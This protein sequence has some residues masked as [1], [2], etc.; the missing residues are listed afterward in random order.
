MKTAVILPAFNEEHNLAPL[1]ARLGH[2]AQ[3]AGLEL[4]IVAVNDGSADDTGRVLAELSRAHGWVHVVE[5]VKNSGLGASIR[6]GIT[7]ALDL[8][9]EAVVMMDADRSHDPDSL[10]EFLKAIQ[11]G[12]DLVLGSRFVSGG[13]MVGVPLWRRLISR[14]GNAIG[15]RVLAIK[16][17]DLT[18]G[19]RAFR[20]AALR[21]LKLTESGFGIQLEGVIEASAAGCAIAEVPIVLACR[22]TG[23]SSMQYG[24]ALFWAYLRVLLHGRRRI[25]AGRRA[26]R[27]EFAG[28]GA[29]S[30]S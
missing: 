7:S 19:Y 25:R 17:R 30:A 22:A 21:N 6:T 10:P 18:T 5:H 1:V 2:V 14:I 26:R 29:R 8:G 3:A 28:S 24:P 12:C 15:R 27:A 4:V 9:C 16:A 23:Q 13:R 11:S 20:T